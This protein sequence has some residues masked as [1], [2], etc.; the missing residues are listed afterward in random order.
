[1]S[2]QTLKSLE[3]SLPNNYFMRVHRSYIVNRNK[4]KSLTGRNLLIEN[5]NIPVSETYLEE[6]KKSLF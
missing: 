3:T 2:H 4:V 6:V 5:F 1:M